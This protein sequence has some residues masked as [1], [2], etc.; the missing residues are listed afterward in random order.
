MLS[1][2]VR[3]RSTC[4]YKDDATSKRCTCIKWLAGTLPGRTGRFRVSAKTA[5]W[6]QAEGVARQYETAASGGKDMDAAMSLPTV[7][8]AVKDYLGDARARGLAEDTIKKL[9]TLFEK[10]L[11]AFCEKEEIRFLRD[12]KTKELTRWRQGWKMGQLA[13]KKQHERVVGFF[14][15]CIRQGWIQQNPTQ[16]MG[17]IIAR[18]TPTDYFPESKYATILDACGRL[19]EGLKRAYDIE[20]R[21]TRIRALTEL[22]RWSGLRIRDAVTLEKTRLE[23]N[24]LFLYQAKTGVPVYVVLPPEVADALNS[25]PPGPKPNPRYFFWS[26]NGHP[27]SAVADWQ[28]AFRRLFEVAALQKPDGSPKRSHPHMF[29]DTFAVELLLAGVPIDQVSVLLGHKSV[30]ITEK[31]YAPWVKARQN[32]LEKAVQMAWRREVLPEGSQLPAA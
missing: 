24:K 13:K 4:K 2:Y 25:L 28:R 27:K 26:G 32:Q 30:K 7:K 19:D 16:A 5:S 29:R 3:H 17:K 10:Q 21:G 18:Q 9:T 1:V 6:E 8:D 14:W 15:F 23:G 22:M 12:L 20:K 11:L 31:H